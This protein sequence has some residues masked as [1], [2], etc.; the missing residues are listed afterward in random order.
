MAAS[1]DK[2]KTITGVIQRFLKRSTE[3]FLQEPPD[4]HTMHFGIG[5]PSNP[6]VEEVL[7]EES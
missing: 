5:G 3:H 2:Q 1:N 7:T 6:F 4:E